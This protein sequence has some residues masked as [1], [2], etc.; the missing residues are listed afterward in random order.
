MSQSLQLYDNWCTSR[1]QSLQES[2]QIYQEALIKSGYDHQVAHQKIYTQQKRRNQNTQKK[3]W[4]NPPYSKNVS[5]KIGNQFLKLIN[6]HSPRH[7]RFYK[8]FNK[9]NVKVSYICMSN[10]KNIIKCITNRKDNINPP[11]DNITRTCNYIRK[12]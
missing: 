8:L 11:E 1:I 3:I 6:K 7:H 10:M 9:N 4:F 12:H 5:T 2:T